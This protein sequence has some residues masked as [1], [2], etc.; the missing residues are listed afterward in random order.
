[1]K[2]KLIPMALCLWLGGCAVGPTYQQPKVDVES[3]YGASASRAA[4]QPSGVTTQPAVMTR[5]W[6]AFNDPVLDA[7]IERSVKANHD[8]RLARARVREARARRAAVVAG[9]YPTADVAGTY[10]R[11]RFSQNA[12]PYDAFQLPGFPWEADMYQVGFDA[13]WEIDVFGAVRRGTE[14][15]TADQEAVVEDGSA[16]LLSVMA[17]VARNYV[18]LRGYQRRLLIA[19]GNLQSQRQTVDLTMDRMKKGVATQ[20]DVSRATSQAAKTEA[21]IPTMDQ[22]QWQAI[23]RLGVLTGGQPMSL[24]AELT[25]HEAIPSPPVEIAVGV[26]AELLR[27]RPDIRRAERQFAAA[28]ARVGVAEANLYPRFALTGM[29]AMQSQHTT[30]LLDWPSRTFS[31]GPAI[32]WPIFDA[33]KLRELVRASDAQWEQ[34]LLAYEQTVLRA[35][36]EVHDSMM[37]F[38]SQQERLRSLGQAVKSDQET[39][40]MAKQLYEQG[41]TDFLSVLDAERSLYTSQDDMAASEQTLA[42]SLVSLYKALGGGW[43]ADRK[44]QETKADTEADKSQ[45]CTMPAK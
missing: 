40:A 14:A 39:V 45:T 37:A 34:A 16:V 33:G 21:M 2:T 4:T 20:L 6:T 17:E 9:E 23:H 15:A 1:M 10:Q 12:A 26:P 24:A 42:T 41:L 13:S 28:T 38:A 27:R 3:D 22:L 35:E 44:A 29:F 31:I 25:G 30:N 19:Q 36:E 5:W 8:V 32:S 18:E 43:E 7:L 11:Q